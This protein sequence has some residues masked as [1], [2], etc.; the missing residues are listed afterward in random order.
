MTTMLH[1]SVLYSSDSPEVSW[2]EKNQEPINIFK[3]ARIIHLFLV[4]LTT[5]LIT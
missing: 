4:Y 1:H 2:I 3:E 5:P